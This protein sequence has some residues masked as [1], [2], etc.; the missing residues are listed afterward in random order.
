MGS[1]QYDKTKQINILHGLTEE[2]LSFKTIC[3]S[4]NYIASLNISNDILGVVE[5][6]RNLRN[7]IHL[8]GDTC[9]TPNIERL[10]GSATELMINFINDRIVEN[11]N[12]IIGK[13]GLN[14]L[15]LN[16]L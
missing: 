16:K 9:E 3:N 8:P 5:N 7:Q 12:N 15:P 4:Q 13:R 10:G 2:S 6:Y 1:F 11:S 14:F